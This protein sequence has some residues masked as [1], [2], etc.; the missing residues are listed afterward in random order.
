[1]QQIWHNYRDI[2][3]YNKVPGAERERGARIDRFDIMGSGK[4]LFAL[5]TL[6]SQFM[7]AFSNSQQNENPSVD[8]QRTGSSLLSEGVQLRIEKD[9]V[10]LCLD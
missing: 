5:L 6:F 4:I 7:A 9:Y 8:F 3:S 2:K 10:T 1:M